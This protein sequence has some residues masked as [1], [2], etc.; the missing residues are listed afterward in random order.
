MNGGR[1][2]TWL[3]GRRVQDEKKTDRDP[4]ADVR[5]VATILLTATTLTAGVLTAFGITNDRVPYL[6]DDPQARLLLFILGGLTGAALLCGLIAQLAHPRWGRVLVALGAVALVM[7]MAFGL[8]AAS[9]AFGGNGRPTITAVKVSESKSEV[10]VAFT[11]HADGVNADEKLSVL[12]G[13]R[14]FS[15]SG[16]KPDPPASYRAV[17]R[18]NDKGVVDQVVTFTFAPPRTADLLVIR[19]YR[20]ADE[21]APDDAIG[22]SCSGA[23]SAACVD[24]A[25]P[26]Q[27]LRRLPSSRAPALGSQRASSL[28]SP[29]GRR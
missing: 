14:I 9:A 22:Q 13:V 28:A 21:L 18:P 4:E 5:S 15:K 2:M 6:L 26:P 29:P 12:S 17:L 23:E 24:V 27:E 20:E 7:G 11:V 1:S 8:A 10:T 3:A 25:L 16:Y 19:A